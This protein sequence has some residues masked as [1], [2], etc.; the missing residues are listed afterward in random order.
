MADDS[1]NVAA[2]L[3]TLRGEMAAGFEKLDGKLNLVVQAQATVARDVEAVNAR[4]NEVEGRVTALEAR[5][6]PLGP[7][8]ALSGAVG[9][10]AAVATYLVAR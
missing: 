4:V 9:A 7:V 5:R 3:A 10:V 8:A 2:A 1:V 6:W